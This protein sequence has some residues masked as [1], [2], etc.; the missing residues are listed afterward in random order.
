MITQDALEVEQGSDEWRKAR[1][2]YVSASSISAVMAKGAGKTRQSYLEKIVAERL[3]EE[4]GEGFSNAS[5]EWGTQTEPQA[6][7]AYEVSCE[8]FVTKTGFHKHPTIEWVGV[9]PDGLLDAENALVEIKC[10]NTTTH[11]SYMKEGKCPAE[12]YKQIQC[13][14]WVTGRAYCDFISYDPRLK[15]QNLRLFVIKVK[16]DEE[17]IAEMESEVIKFLADVEKYIKE[18]P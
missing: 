2:G 15:N 17:L 8:T 4:I 18:L 6:R 11:L 10:P 16:R 9:S 12:Y 3:T 14:L 1:L 7:M 13:Q 5:M